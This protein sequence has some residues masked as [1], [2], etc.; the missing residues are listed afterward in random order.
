MKIGPEEVARV[1]RLARLE[2]SEEKLE[3]FAPQLDDILRYMDKLAEVDTTGVE[4]M[5]SPVEHVSVLRADEPAVEYDRDDVLSNAP[6]TDGKFF[7]VP[8]IV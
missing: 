8:R 7:I 5:Y 2:L 4:P 6:E 1:A 3:T